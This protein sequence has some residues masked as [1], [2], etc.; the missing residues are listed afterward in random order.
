MDLQHRGQPSIVINMA[1]TYNK[2]MHQC[3]RCDLGSLVTYVLIAVSDAHAY[4]FAIS[5]AT[6]GKYVHLRSVQLHKEFHKLARF[7]YKTLL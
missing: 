2:A 7:N 5:V 4:A 1:H 3:V 6:T